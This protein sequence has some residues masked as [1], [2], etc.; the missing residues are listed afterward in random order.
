MNIG[1]RL[2]SR[3]M[4]PLFLTLIGGTALL[5]SLA[6]LA[7][8]APVSASSED[9]PTALERYPEVVGTRLQTCALCHTADGMSTNPFG[10]AYMAQGRGP[11]ALAAIES[12]DSDGDGYSNIQE[13][14]AL[15]LPGFDMDRPTAAAQEGNNIFLPILI[16]SSASAGAAP[17]VQP[18][19]LPTQS[20]T[21]PPAND[22]SGE[23]ILVGAGDISICGNPGAEAT[24]K[25][26]DKIPGEIFTAGD[27]SNESA[28]AAQLANCFHP[29]WGR[30]K[31]RIHP[32]AGNHDYLSH[33]AAPYFA[34]FGAAAGSPQKGYYSYDLGAWHIVVLNSNC[35]QVGGCKAGSPQE[36]WL[37]ADLA[38]HPAKCSLAVWHHARFSSGQQGN[39]VSMQDIWQTLYNVGT[40]LVINGHDHVYERFA[41]QDPTGKADPVRGIREF[42]VG[43]GGASHNPF[44]RPIPNSD[45]RIPGVFGVLKLSLRPESYSWEFVPEAGKTQT[46]AGSADCH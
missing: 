23:K 22:P 35:S 25:L 31:A 16:S 1:N 11:D 20:P 10:D 34:Y 19:P 4:L 18:T 45:V 27:N 46:D 32:A 12:M 13:I 15:T 38:A 33:N 17:V 44:L 6:M 14:K 36:Q 43:T 2:K 29:T 9:Y 30:H 42:I 40:E 41:P 39:Y 3:R 24:A 5:T 7:N 21:Q 37:K 8:P 26:L 28:T